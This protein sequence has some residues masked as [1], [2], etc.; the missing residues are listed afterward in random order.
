MPDYSPEIGVLENLTLIMKDLYDPLIDQT[1]QE[2]GAFAAFTE[3]KE[4]QLSGHKKKIYPLKIGVSAGGIGVRGQS[5]RLPYATDQKF[6]EAEATILY[7][8]SVLELSGQ[9]MRIPQGPGTM[10][11]DYLADLVEGNLMA[12][13][14]DSARMVMEDGLGVM[15]TVVSV[16]AS[17]V[18]LVD[19]T[20]YFEAGQR[21]DAWDGATVRSNG[22]TGYVIEEVDEDN[23]LLTLDD[24]TDIEA[25]DVL[26]RYGNCEVEDGSRVCLEFP[27]WKSIIAATGTYL[28][29][30]KAAHSYWRPR[31]SANGGTPRDL[32]QILMQKFVDDNFTKRRKPVPENIWVD[33]Q[34][35]RT[36]AH[37]LRATNQPQEPILNVFGRKVMSFVYGNSTFKINCDPAMPAGTINFINYKTFER[38]IAA[39]AG[40][41]PGPISSRWER[42]SGYDL[43][44]AVWYKYW[45]FA[46]KN[47]MLNGQIADLDNA[48]SE[49]D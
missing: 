35:D 4:A 33:P 12:L 6:D 29:I 17:N 24:N 21:V 16:R 36:L 3:A 11:T 13:Q 2:S 37:M 39:P 15:G 10:I 26:V 7:Y 18:L 25:D 19:D 40:W 28:G 46:C 47:P 14:R 22:G 41:I 31:V 43:Y 32:T 8:Y 48:D 1:E 5:S 34:M 20:K 49:T 45:G 9:E 30:D 42:Y 44:A 23:N 38:L 27:G